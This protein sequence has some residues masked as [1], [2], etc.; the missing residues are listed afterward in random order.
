MEAVRF[1]WLAILEFVIGFEE[2]RFLG[3]GEETDGA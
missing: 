2:V 3:E 1:L